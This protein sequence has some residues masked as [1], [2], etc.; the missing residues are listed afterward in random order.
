MEPKEVPF[1]QS[2]LAATLPETKLGTGLKN[3]FLPADEAH[4][5]SDVDSSRLAYHHTIGL[6]ANQVA[7]G[8]HNHD[9]ANSRLIPGINDVDL[10]QGQ[11]VTWTGAGANPAVNNGSLVFEY[12][13]IGKAIN[14]TF[15]LI[16]GTTTTYGTGKYGFLLPFNVNGTLG[17]MVQGRIKNGASPF[18]FPCTAFVDPGTNAVTD[19][20]PSTTQAVGGLP[21]TN[22]GWKAAWAANDEIIISGWVL[23]D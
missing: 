17:W 2:K 22:T 3:S 19:I 9:G 16:S 7:G 14:F 6:S 12:F 5:N 1:N 11:F 4:F 10:V 18:Y 20:F 21:L 8:L 13:K 15:R 23:G